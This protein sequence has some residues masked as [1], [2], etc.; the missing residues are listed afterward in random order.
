MGR[1]PRIDD[2]GRT[3]RQWRERVLAHVGDERL[4]HSSQKTRRRKA[5]PVQSIDSEVHKFGGHAVDTK[6]YEVH[7]SAVILPNPFARRRPRDAGR[8]HAASDHLQ[9]QHTR[10]LP[11]L[12]TASVT[13]TTTTTTPPTL[14]RVAAQLTRLV[15]SG[16]TRSGAPLGR[17]RLTTLLL[18]DAFLA[19]DP[20][21]S[22]LVDR[23]EWSGAMRRL[24]VDERLAQPLFDEM[25]AD[26]TGSPLVSPSPAPYS[27]GGGHFT[28]NHI[29]STQHV[30]V[31]S[32][33]VTSSPVQSSPC[34][35]PLSAVLVY[36]ELVG[37]VE[38]PATE[39][40]ERHSLAERQRQRQMRE[41]LVQGSSEGAARSR[42]EG[43]ARLAPGPAR[44]RV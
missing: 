38:R 16:T 7:A 17:A 24:G 18:S 21:E 11:N 20:T 9:D 8:A 31:E 1:L 6:D 27:I 12:G 25:V 44:S 41:R 2:R 5:A 36:G 22:G 4:G 29:T 42:F 13:S 19:V 40:D 34:P 39:E 23:S 43:A 26:T 15:A 28:S 37:A 32:S 14:D 3:Q 35:C 30:V 33:R 10:M